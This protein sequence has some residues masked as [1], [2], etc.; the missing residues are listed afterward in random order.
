[1]EPVLLQ[2]ENIGNEKP[3]E[4]VH[5]TC[6]LL[7]ILYQVAFALLRREMGRNSSKILLTAEDLE[8]KFGVATRSARGRGRERGGGSPEAS[9]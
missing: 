2:I 6:C 1:M 4:P 3:L 7:L 9:E 5:S 8:I